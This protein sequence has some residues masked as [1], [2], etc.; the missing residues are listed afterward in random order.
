[1]NPRTVAFVLTLLT[2]AGCTL[3]KS[4]LRR[5]NR[6]AGF[7]R[8]VGGSRRRSLAAHRRDRE[9]HTK[10]GSHQPSHHRARSGDS[11]TGPASSESTM[12]VT[13]A[14]SAGPVILRATRPSGEMMNVS[15]TPYSP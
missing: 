3:N 7:Q 8:T 9:R 13:A 1:M 6:R 15:G 5:D 10:E 14:A 11:A 12:R 4:E 2:V